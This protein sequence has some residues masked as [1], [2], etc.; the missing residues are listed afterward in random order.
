MSIWTDFQGAG[1]QERYYNVGGVRTRV[2]EAGEGGERPLLLLHGTTGHAEAYQRN[3]VPLSRD[4]RVLAVDTLGHGYTDRHDKD[5]SL[6]DFVDH[7]VGL[8]DEI[9]AEKV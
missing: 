5:Y 3:L 9:G 1:V 7:L 8:A 2:L 4:R 6:D